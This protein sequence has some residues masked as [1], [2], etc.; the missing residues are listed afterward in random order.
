MTMDTITAYTREEA[1]KK[2]TEMGYNVVKLYRF[3][4]LV[5]WNEFST[6]QIKIHGMTRLARLKM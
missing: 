3:S 5:K 6:S 1:V 2:A 4:N